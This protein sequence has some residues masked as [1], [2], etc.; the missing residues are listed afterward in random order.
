[1]YTHEFFVGALLMLSHV[2]SALQPRWRRSPAFEAKSEPVLSLREG[3]LAV[4]TYTSAASKLKI[5]SAFVREGLE[6]GDLVFYT[7]PDEEEAT[8]RQNLKQNGVDVSKCER[9]GSLVLMNL[10]G[11]YLAEGEFDKKKIIKRELEMRAKAKRKG[12]KHF[13]DLGDVGDFSFLKGQWQTYVDYW[14]D[15]DWG[16][17][18]GSGLG[19]LYEPFI[20]EL[21]AINV[22]GMSETTVRT[23]TNAFRGGKR[24]P[25]KL[26][27]FLEY[28]QAFSKRI[29]I[30]HDEL[31]GRTLL[32]EFDPASDYEGIVESYA[33][34]ALAN[35]EPIYVFTRNVSGV[36]ASLA[37]QPSVRFVLMSASAAISKS[38]SSNEVVLPV[39]NT[40]L[41]L[42]LLRE[43][44][45]KHSNENVFLVFD[46]LTELIACVGL[47]K[48]YKFLLYVVEMVSQKNATALFLFNKSAHELNAVSQIRGLFNDILT[49]ENNQLAIVKSSHSR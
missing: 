23:I 7:Y 34:E 33:K 12:Y 41:I 25:T 17:P 42:N 4:V 15:P 19:V 47:D 30:S 49:Y 36:R 45:R 22:E 43:T 2:K 37:L 10:T 9:D 39:D 27:D 6:S 35:L 32:L 44:L 46:N 11:H 26:I 1:M 38:I 28:A 13:R 29:G 21:T 8:V 14:D 48:A 31:I 16:I 18:S 5:F 40:P 24:S 3:E 20:M